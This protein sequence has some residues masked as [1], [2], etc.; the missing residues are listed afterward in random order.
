MASLPLG[1]IRPA[2]FAIFSLVFAAA[3]A[4]AG[5]RPDIYSFTAAQ[6]ADLFTQMSNYITK[7]A[8]EGHLCPP[9]DKH[10]SSRFVVWH[11]DYIKG[12]E[13]Y[14]ISQNR[15]QFVP[16]PKWVPSTAIPAEFLV[17]G[18]VDPNC[19]AVAAC[20]GNPA[21]CDPLVDS[22]PNV[23]L[24]ASLST[25]LCSQTPFTSF[26]ATLE[27][28]YH[29]GV[30]GAIGGVMGWYESP[31]AP[32]FWL[33]HAHVD[34]IWFDWQCVCGLDEGAA[35]DTYTA[36]ERITNLDAGIAD[37][38]MRDSDA[39][40]ANEP[41]NE[42]GSVLWQSKDIWVRNSAAT[43]VGSTRYLN[44]HQHQNPEY[45]ALPANRPYIY[46]KVRNRGCT[47]VSGQLHV[48]WANASVGL[49]WPT[50]FTEVSTSPVTLTS[51]SA[52]REH[53]AQFHWLDIPV[54]GG[55]AG[56]HFCLLARFEATPNSA[57]PIT[58][59][60]VNVSVG[61]NVKNSNQIAWKNVTVVDNITNNFAV[62]VRNISTLGNLL[63]LRFSVPAAQADDSIFR[64]ANISIDLGSVLFGRWR[65]NGSMGNAI[66]IGPAA[67]T[68]LILGPD[69][70]ID[71]LPVAFNEQFLVNMRFGEGQVP[72][73][74]SDDDTTFDLIV[75]ATQGQNVLGGN[76]YHYIPRS[77]RPS[78][79][80]A[81]AAPGPRVACA[82]GQGVLL[83]AVASPPPGA[84][85]VSY[86]WF[87]DGLPISG[88]TQP[89]FLANTSGE[90]SA[91]VAYSN[92]CDAMSDVV[93]VYIGTPPVNDN[94]CNSTPLLL[95]IPADFDNFCATAQPGEV[96]PGAGT[97]P[98]DGCNST[99]GW[100]ADETAIQNSV[101]YHFVPPST[102]MYS[103]HLGTHTGH[104]HMNGQ[105]AVY[106]VGVCTDYGSFAEVGANDDAQLH[107]L[108]GADPE[109]E[110][111]LLAGTRYYIQFDGYQGDR[112][113]GTIV[114][115]PGP[116]T[117]AC[118]CG[119]HC[120]ITTPTA[121]TGPN[122]S[123]A[124]LGTVCTPFS[125]TSPC[126][127][128]DYNKSG[129]PPTVQ[130]IF[131]FLFGY[132]SGDPCADTNDSGGANSVQDL[133]DFLA[134][135]FSGC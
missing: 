36:A 2:C 76:N 62:F 49:T 127:R 80:V 116:T 12:M 96:S 118:C 81:Y 51:I 27:N 119:S 13:D 45:A 18:G 40:V 83:Q 4:F 108:W 14:L 3:A 121:C 53:V 38:W 110:L 67:N 95:G 130:D 56:N 77:I 52:G 120:G 73:P 90:Y 107:G 133:F 58:G 54:P 101:W 71:G 50:N 11:R 129:A 65:Q 31:G 109:L 7:T 59:E 17:G 21:N 92:G 75:T 46:V 10:G 117:G 132:F 8:I 131:D 29:N 88:A 35:F 69:A 68:L 42:T 105:L 100:C 26:R 43:P 23:A 9:A 134:A 48:Y 72:A 30:H 84:T 89:S 78:P 60:A 41:N 112:G 98:L 97:G 20:G 37:A 25:N 19:A 86:Q 64:H 16:L 22:T 113:Q 66:E 39:D 125:T 122:R 124:G 70:S 28:S 63:S 94:P 44:E 61:Q 91:R 57:D 126:C 123:F 102:G 135:Y 15:P 111:N 5:D 79:P 47:T 106:R 128:G 34:D 115:E 74:C 24:P 87:R 103:I 99:N 114:V 55:S 82:V 104:D 1:S 93:E 6:R 33:W 85:I 32:I